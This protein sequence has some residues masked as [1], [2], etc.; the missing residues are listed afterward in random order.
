MQLSGSMRDPR[1]DFFR[2]VAMLIIYVAH[3]PFNFW[4]FWI[5]SQFGFSDSTEI[6]VFCS[7][8]ASAIA[9]GGTFRRQGFWMGTARVGF[10]LWQVY[11]AHI[12]LFLMVTTAM[13]GLNQWQQT[14]YHLRQ[15]NLLIF[16]ENTPQNLLGLMTLTYV[17]NYFD[18]LP[19]YLVILLLLPLMMLLSRW[20]RLAVFAAMV[21]FWSLANLGYLHLPAEPWSDRPWFFNPFAWQLLFF[22]GFAW[23]MGWLPPPPRRRDALFI[24]LVILLVTVPIDWFYLRNQFPWLQILHREILPFIDKGQFG[25]LRFVH[26]LALA[27][28]AFY[29]VGEQG[30]HLQRGGIFTRILCR[31]GQQ[32][33]PVF[34][35]SM[36][37]AQFFGA[38]LYVWNAPDWMVNLVNVGGI[39]LLI[40]IAYLTAWFKSSPW[41]RPSSHASTAPAVAGD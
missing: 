40:G 21:V 39:A 36:F 13:I 25:L 38:F 1:L 26:F 20:H 23:R 31:V 12:A 9:F 34:L 30:K 35:S 29:L 10:R 8:M 7:G 15:L 16:F 3:L 27:Y 2:G 6:F 24:A 11:W 28:L 14:D 4:V 18:I 32:T 5:P 33:L 17:P 19:M 41:R 37:L 22:T